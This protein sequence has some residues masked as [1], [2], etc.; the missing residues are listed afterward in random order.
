MPDVPPIPTHELL[1]PEPPKPEPPKAEPTPPP[2][3]PPM[4]PTPP[5]TP[6]TPAATEP[7]ITTAGGTAVAGSVGSITCQ[8]LGPWDVS[9]E[10]SCGKALP[11]FYENTASFDSD[12]DRQRKVRVGGWVR[13][14]DRW[15]V[16]DGRRHAI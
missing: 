12:S 14:V 4:P 2:P 8:N 6:P 16:V 3:P 5:P 1:Q 15:L 10:P 11:Q 9:A 7:D 13:W